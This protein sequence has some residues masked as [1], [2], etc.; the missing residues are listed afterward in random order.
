MRRHTWLAHGFARWGYTI[1]RFR[2]LIIVLAG[3]V[4]LACLWV[5]PTLTFDANLLHQQAH[6]T[7]SVIWEQRVIAQAGRSSWFALATAPT[8]EEAAE[9]AARFESLPIVER[10]ET[11]GFAAPKIQEERLHL[12]TQLQPFLAHLPRTVPQ[13]IVVSLANMKQTLERLNFKLQRSTE[14]WDPQQKPSDQEIAGVRAL[15][16]R[17]LARLNTSQEDETRAALERLQ[18]PLIADFAERWSLL[19]NNLYPAGPLSLADLPAQV[20]ERFVRADGQQFLLQIYSRHDIWDSAPLTTFVSQLRQVDPNVTGSPI[21][22]YESIRAIQRGYIEG[23]LYAAC[24]TLLVTLLTLRK[25]TDVLL[26]MLPVVGGMLW[27]A[28]L[29]RLFHLQFNLA[30]LVVVPITLGIG[31][32]SGLYLVR[33]ARAEGHEGWKVVGGSTGQAVTLFSLSTMVGFGSLLI[34]RHYGIFS[35]GLLLVLAVSSTLAISLVVLPLFLRPEAPRVTL[36]RIGIKFP[37]A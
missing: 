34:S 37:Q 30:N 21:I 18:T 29:M 17:L 12:V 10:V 7:E 28:G 19:Q 27:T 11:L 32:E 1:H 23:G 16:T 2:R 8:L 3:G 13:A 4:S 26:A 5:L 33:R 20:R 36:P 6:E 15:L 9:K 14:D 22:G 24:A 25:L 31:V 35:M